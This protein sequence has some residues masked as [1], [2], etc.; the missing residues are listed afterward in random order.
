MN[1][2]AYNYTFSSST[3]SLKAVCNLSALFE[4]NPLKPI[5]EQISTLAQQYGTQVTGYMLALQDL[6]GRD[7]INIL[8]ADIPYYH[9]Y[10]SERVDS[11]TTKIS[12]KSA[13]NTF[14]HLENNGLVDDDSSACLYISL[15]Q[16]YNLFNA[17]ES[18]KLLCVVA[19]YLK[20]LLRF[21]S[22]DQSV[23]STYEFARGLQGTDREVKVFAQLFNVN[24]L[25]ANE[26]H[27]IIGLYCGKSG[28][29]PDNL[30]VLFNNGRHWWGSFT[31]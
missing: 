30:I 2:S 18:P 29:N 13:S 27:E 9:I 20:A 19:H 25:V 14:H 12:R 10:D 17:R 8:L 7:N 4:L 6:R 21:Y 28:P 5:N 22:A 16:S 1:L 3:S 15:A 11:W 26:R 24:V 23:F 31:I